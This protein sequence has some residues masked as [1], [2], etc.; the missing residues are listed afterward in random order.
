MINRVNSY[1]FDGSHRTSLYPMHLRTFY[2]KASSELSNTEEMSSQEW[3]NFIFLEISSANRTYLE[4][5][6]NS[7]NDLVGKAQ[8]SITD[9]VSPSSG[10]GGKES[11]SC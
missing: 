9:H 4:N 8:V 7:R 1:Y 10:I 2:T 3:A 5:I 11:K 6:T